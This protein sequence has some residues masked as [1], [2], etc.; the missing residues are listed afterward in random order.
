[1][2]K[3][4]LEAE[5]ELWPFRK[6]MNHVLE[7]NR[8]TSLPGLQVT[9][10]D[11]LTLKLLQGFFEVALD[12]EYKALWNLVT[13]ERLWFNWISYEWHEWND[14]LVAAEHESTPKAGVHTEGEDYQG[15]LTDKISALEKKEFH[16]RV[17]AIM[18]GAPKTSH[19]KGKKKKSQEEDHTVSAFWQ[20]TCRDPMCFRR[21][22]TLSSC[23]CKV[24]RT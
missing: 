13:K 22:W 6:A 18:E 17:D 4:T 21:A 10:Q 2:Y 9:M 19:A 16:K 15:A 8:A 5:A 1:M 7:R 12:E 20:L 24:G 11:I 14:N 3:P 23:I